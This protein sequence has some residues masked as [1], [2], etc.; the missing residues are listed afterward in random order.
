MIAASRGLAVGRGRKVR[1]PQGSVPDNVR[2]GW[3]KPAGRPVQQK[4]DRLRL[5]GWASQE[6]CPMFAACGKGE[7]VG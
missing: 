5:L 4:I 3:L 2:D 1:T 7:T 6:V